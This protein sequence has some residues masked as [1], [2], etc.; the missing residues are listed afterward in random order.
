M[1]YESYLGEKKLN[2]YISEPRCPNSKT[3][4]TIKSKLVLEAAKGL[5]SN[6]NRRQQENM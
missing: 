3:G 5:S 4:R 1:F 6:A 2:N